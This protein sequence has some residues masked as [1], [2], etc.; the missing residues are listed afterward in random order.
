MR[1]DESAPKKTVKGY[2]EGRNRLE[3]PEEERETQ[4][5]RMLREC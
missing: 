4:L 5:R 2:V 3:G 1:K